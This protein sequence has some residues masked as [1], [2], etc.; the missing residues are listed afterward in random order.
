[1]IFFQVPYHPL[2]PVLPHIH[3]LQWQAH[4]GVACFLCSSLCFGGRGK[5][6][7]YGMILEAVKARSVG[8]GGGVPPWNGGDISFSEP[9]C[10]WPRILTCTLCSAFPGELGS[11]LF[12]THILDLSLPSCVTLDKL[13]NLA[14]SSVQLA[15]QTEVQIFL[16]GACHCHLVNKHGIS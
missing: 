8:K 4:P 1:M 12:R 9:G 16:E 3:T 7:L 6:K 14:P 13:L 15:S 10:L 2:R 5:P 11:L